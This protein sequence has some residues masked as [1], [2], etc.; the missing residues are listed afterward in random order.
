MSFFVKFYRH[1]VLRMPILTLLVMTA[2]AG[3]CVWQARNFF[4]DASADSLILEHDPQLRLFREISARYQSPALLAV[5]YTPHSGDVFDED[6]LTRLTRLRDEIRALPDVQS[7]LSLLDAPLFRNPPVPLS[8]VTENVRTLEEPGVDRLLARDEI[9]HSEIYRQQLICT[10]GRTAVLAITLKDNGELETIHNRRSVLLMAMDRHEAVTENRAAFERLTPDLRRLQKEDGQRVHATIT[11]LRTILGG[12]RDSAEVHLGGGPMISDDMLA[13]VR[14]DLR[15]FGFA[16]FVCIAVILKYFFGS[17]RWV[18]LAILCCAYSTLVMV[19]LLGA[20]SWPVTIIS[21]NFISLLLIITM[22]LVI[23]LIVQYRELIR[24]TPDIDTVDAVGQTVACKWTPCLYCTLTTIAGFSSLVLCDI[25]PVKDF[26]IMMS[27][28]LVVSMVTS[29]ILFPAMLVLFPKEPATNDRDVGRPVTAWAERMVARSGRWIVVCAGLVILFIGAGMCGLTVENS[30]AANFRKTSE[31]YQ[32]MVFIDR[33]LG[34]TTPVDVIIQLPA[35]PPPKRAVAATGKADDDFSEFE[36]IDKTVASDAY[37][38]TPV[39]LTL[40]RRAHDIVEARP[41]TGKVSSMASLLKLTDELNDGVAIDAFEL[42]IL[43]GKLPEFA[44]RMLVTPYV[45]VS[46]N[47][48]RITARVFD[49]QPG[50]RRARFLHEL[51]SDLTR[52]LNLPAGSIR[53]TGTMVLYNGVL[54][55]LFR[56]QILTLGL[57]FLLLLAMF[58]VLFR[59]LKI[60]LIALFPNFLSALTVL[61]FL[62]AAHIPLDVMTITIASISIGIA[63][64]ATIHYIH[65]M[66]EEFAVC[67]NYLVAMRA[68]HQSVGSAMYFTSLTIVIG[69][70]LLTFSK[71]MPSVL[72]GLLTSLAMVIA[73]LGALTL[74]PWMLVVLRPFGPEQRPAK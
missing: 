67:G 74:L 52:G 72:F 59:S 28:A 23:H 34:G 38:Y 56:S 15:L 18:L 66:R 47:Q 36:E 63:V 5:T 31:I 2:V 46:N 9:V 27:L 55:S 65:R 44:S 71:F 17:L 20:C 37:W 35:D 4:L 62:G 14:S 19:G 16:I 64:D 6:N 24:H 51:E 70:S 53:L 33:E 58:L 8:R 43:I 69:F 41:E 10:N 26:G 57:T 32:G 21:S 25:K 61:G 39:K 30:F 68:S 54:Q 11:R 49:S 7:V 40:A 45:S 13:Y 60:A 29:F 12:Y 22:S 42:A 48:L 1:A 3:V 50:L 73:F